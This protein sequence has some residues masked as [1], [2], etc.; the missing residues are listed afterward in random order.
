MEEFKE[1]LMYVGAA[2]IGLPLGFGIAWFI[3]RGHK[4]A[5]RKVKVSWVNGPWE[6]L[7]G[8]MENKHGKTRTR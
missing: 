1:F 8:Y 3:D 7:K 2:A 5:I 4:K 6:S